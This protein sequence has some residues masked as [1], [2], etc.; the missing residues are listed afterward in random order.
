MST[1]RAVDMREGVGVSVAGALVL[2]VVR[3]DSRHAPR[4][5]FMA[6]CRLVGRRRRRLLLPI[7][8]GGGESPAWAVDMRGLA[9]GG[10][11]HVGGWGGCVVACRLSGSMCRRSVRP[12]GFVGGESSV[13]IVDMRG[14]GVGR[15]RWRLGRGAWGVAGRGGAGRVDLGVPR[16]IR[17]FWLFRRS[18]PVGLS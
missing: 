7:G 13:W 5:G 1:S 10:A 14:D 17:R 15:A 9:R 4:P 18:L 12:I 2:R 6:A 11:G 8:S 16:V 3:L